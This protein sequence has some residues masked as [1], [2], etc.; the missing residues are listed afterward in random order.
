MAVRRRNWRRQ[1]P[2]ST[3]EQR[4]RAR[5]RTDWPDSPTSL[6]EQGPNFPKSVQIAVRGRVHFSWVSLVGLGAC[7]NLNTTHN[8]KIDWRWA[9]ATAPRVRLAFRKPRSPC[10]GEAREKTATNRTSCRR[11]QTS[12][13][14]T[15]IDRPPPERDRRVL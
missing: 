14:E 4:V 3:L 10:G 11:S 13:E 2:K 6:R 5:P 7:E 8:P 9:I 1:P 12:S 15:V